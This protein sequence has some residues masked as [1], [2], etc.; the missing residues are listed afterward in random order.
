MPDTTSEALAALATALEGLTV[1]QPT[2]MRDALADLLRGRTWKLPRGVEI[3]TDDSTGVFYVEN[4]HEHNSAEVRQTKI[5]VYAT[6]RRAGKESRGSVDVYYHHGGDLERRCGAYWHGLTGAA[7]PDGARVAVAN[8]ILETINTSA[9]AENAG[10]GWQA[11]ALEIDRAKRAGTVR[12]HIETA[13]RELY[14]ARRMTAQ[15]G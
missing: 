4:Q 7:V 5:S 12:R 15:G 13:A 14:E 10:I 8:A 11:F 2:P 6:V 9:L 3:E 1:S